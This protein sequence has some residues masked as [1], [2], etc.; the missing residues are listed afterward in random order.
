MHKVW[1]LMV[2]GKH[3][4]KI[5]TQ[6]RLLCFDASCCT[7]LIS[8]SILRCLRICRF[9]NIDIQIVQTPNKVLD[10]HRKVN[11][12]IAPGEAKSLLEQ[13]AELDRRKWKT[14]RENHRA[15]EHGGSQLHGQAPKQIV[16]E[17]RGGCKHQVR[18]PQLL[19]KQIAASK[20][21][22]PCGWKASN[23]GQRLR[24]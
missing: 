16:A 19:H 13:D 9:C 15:C 4:V 6:V 2:P 17:V 24:V 7:M 23:R 5:E 22:R 18:V 14:Q 20:F 10:A 12:A 11:S 8:R 21:D 1:S 3:V